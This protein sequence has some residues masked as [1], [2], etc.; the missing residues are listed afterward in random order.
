MT[1]A[2]AIS[3]D[4]AAWRTVRLPHDWS[5]EF[6]FDKER[7]D[8]ATAY[9][10]GGIAWYC[11]QFVCPPQPNT[12]TFILFDGVYNNAELWCNGQP[13]GQNPYGYSP[14]WFE[15][16]SYLRS[17]LDEQVLAV[18]VDHSRYVDSR[19]YTGSGNLPRC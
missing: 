17:D 15:L 5:V 6:S 7:G 16:T 10:L 12:L 13:L 8:G 19:W 14:F 2:H 3:F 18:R 11:K 1:Q 4:D 9:L